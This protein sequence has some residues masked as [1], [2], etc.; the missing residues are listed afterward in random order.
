MGIVSEIVPNRSRLSPRWLALLPAS[1]LALGLDRAAPSDVIG[2]A[3]DAGEPLAKV[4]VR[5]QGQ[6]NS[7]LTDAKGKFQL[8]TKAKTTTVTGWKEGYAIGHA[9]VDRL[10]IEL[11]LTRLPAQD[12]PDYD[13]I[14]PSPDPKQKNNCGNCH[15]KIH[16]EWA[17]SAHARAADNRRFRNLFE[18]TDWHGK[19]SR[20]WNL[21]AEHPLG[22]GVCAG[23]HA[24][25]FRDPALEYDMTKVQGVDK[26][27]VHCDYCHK[28]VDVPTDK[29]GRRFGRDGMQLLR[30]AKGEQLFFGPLDDAVRPG[31]MFG[32]SPLYKESRYCASCHEGVIFGVHVYGTYSEWLE[33]PAK[34]K[35]QQCQDCHM[36]PTGKLT[37]FAPG[38]GG[39]ERDPHTLGSHTLPGATA[40]MLRDCLGVK[41]TIE[42]AVGK[43]NVAVEVLAKNVGHRVPT[44]FIDRHLVLV[45]EGLDAK[46]KPVARKA[47]PTLP[48]SAGE[49]AGQAGKLYAKAL[50]TAQGKPLPFWLADGKPVDNRLAPDQPDLLAFSLG[51]ELDRVR[52][53]LLYRRFWHEVA[54]AKRWPDNEIV[55][56]DRTILVKPA[57][58][59][60]SVRGKAA[61]RALEDS[62]A[63]LGS[64]GRPDQVCPGAT[65]AG[66]LNP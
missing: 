12:N 26:K 64:V 5:C 42:P 65:P 35:G 25:T 52:V 22:T 39:I 58:E 1:L 38:K 20:T 18:G 11:N 10:P 33:S 63:G 53:R 27:G 16:E 44:G 7:T 37:N 9:A 50:W 13:W 32:Y 34:K 55:V 23:C 17:G 60:S 57:R 29:L 40:E 36:K 2:T 43:V 30:P 4:R 19:P 24:P 59:S 66:R 61:P 45:I 14:D 28:V 49:L 62:R 51:P 3:K 6:S 41:V 21:Q 31:D 15:A 8:K 47:G 46:G 56:V 48:K 54:E